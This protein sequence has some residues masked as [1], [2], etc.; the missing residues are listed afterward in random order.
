MTKTQ[1]PAETISLDARCSRLEGTVRAMI[2]L[3]RLETIAVKAVDIQAFANLQ[4]G[5]Y[6][7]FDAYQS[8]VHAMLDHRAQLKTL[9]EGVKDRIRG[10]ERD[11]SLARV[12]NMSVLERAGKSFERLRDRVVHIARD[13]AMRN[14]SAYGANGLM[15]N[16]RRAISTGVQ[17]KA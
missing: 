15:Q 9:P 6:D 1:T 5:K 10:F 8:D 3:L 2:D 17:D 11:L 13:T 4:K 16:A 7:L 14:A 12:E